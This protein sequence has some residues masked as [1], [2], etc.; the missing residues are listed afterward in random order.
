MTIATIYRAR[1]ERR[2]RRTLLLCVAIAGACIV[3]IALI[4][5]SLA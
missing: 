4:R 2:R 5:G 3:T 1:R